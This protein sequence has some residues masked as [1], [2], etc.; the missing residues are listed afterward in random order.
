MTTMPLATPTHLVAGPR[1][2]TDRGRWTLSLAL[3]CLALISGCATPLP[4]VNRDAIES[5][6]IEGSTTT[7]LGKIIAASTPTDVHSGFRLLPLGPFSFDTRLA[8]AE[9]AQVSL[10][11]QYYH[12]EADDTGRNLLRALRDAAAR[13]VR[14][15][16][17]I[18]DLYTG[19]QDELFLGFASHPNVE[20]R[21]FN[22][23][24]RARGSGQAGRFI[25]SIAE[26]KRINHR[27]H[28]KM[29]VADGV[30]AIIGG[31]NV[32]NEYYLRSETDNFID[33]DAFVAGKLV[34]PLAALFD[35]YWNSDPVY[36]LN[37]VARSSLDAG[38]LRDLFEQRTGPATTAPPPPLPS[39]DILGYGPLREDL[40]DGRIGLLW[41]EAY[42]FA[43]HPDKPFDGAVDG[44]LLETSVTYNIIEPMM[45]AKTE[46]VISSPY[47]VPGERGMALLRELRGRGVKVSVI[48][49]SLGSTDEQLVHLGY[50]RYRAEM[51]RLGIELF[52]LSSS[53][54]KRNRR[55]F[56]FGSGLGRLHSKLL[57]IDRQILFIGSMNFDPRSATINTELG[58]IVD[59]KPLAREMTRVIDLD[60]LQSAYR[61]RLAAS[62]L[63]LEWLHFDEDGNE[64]VLTDE[65]DATLWTRLKLWL[66]RPLVAEGLL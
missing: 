6:A 65:P 9:M 45:K 64:Q 37:S 29:F 28:N 59:S 20:V 3:L 23:F 44:D 31:R 39:N 36:P 61:V 53:G 63:G 50:S 4:R 19:G 8:L 12:L 7:T 26:F 14:V 62:G 42:A 24:T 34:V 46:V 15:R 54:V 52:E 60:R 35:R 57:V 43:D 30:A 13:G 17:L 38:A 47:F 22:P 49:N 58:A 21:L 16:L 11:V 5:T 25:A 33:M 55:L 56:H 51:L 40:Q 27:M 32:A 66:L 18:D 1:P 2:A 10:D 41:G 48:T